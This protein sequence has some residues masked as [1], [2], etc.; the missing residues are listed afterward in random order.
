MAI[1]MNSLPEAVPDIDYLLELP[2]EEL[3]GLVLHFVRLQRQ[4]GHAHLA[5]FQSSLFGQNIAGHKYDDRRRNEIEL[6]IAE[7]WSWLEVQGLLISAPGQNGANGFRV[8]SRQ[9]AKLNTVED[10]KKYAKS[11][12]IHKDILHPRIAETVWSAFMRSEFDVAAFQAMK[13]VE[14][15]VREAAEL[16]AGDIGV[17]LMRKAFHEDTGPL[18][19]LGAE[20]GER[21]AR[22]ALFAGAIGCYK[23]PHSHRDVQIT[24]ADEANEIVMLA[25][26]L[27]RIVDQR[28]AAKRSQQS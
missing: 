23:N 18:T 19:D 16:G 11:R 12:R 15:A 6:A 13:A 17:S 21:Q 10:V 5:N 28:K 14:V 26:H 4:Y 7:A 3:A 20:V 22:S 24:E 27:L 1:K 9:A 8:F 2:T 25:N